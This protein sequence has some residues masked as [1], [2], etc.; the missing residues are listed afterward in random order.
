MSELNSSFSPLPREKLYLNAKSQRNEIDKIVE[1]VS[2]YIT[3]YS[4]STNKNIG[5]VAGSAILAGIDSMFDIGGRV[6]IFSCNSCVSG[7]GACKIR[8]ENNL[9]NTENERN[10]Y[11]PQHDKFVKLSESLT[12]KRIAV[13]LFIFGTKQFDLATFSPIANNTGGSVFFYNIDFNNENDMKYKFEKL[14]YNL[15]RVLTRENFYDVKFM[16][17]YGNSFEVMEILGPFKKRLGSGLSIPSCDPDFSMSFM[18]R[19]NET[20]KNETRQSFQLVALYINNFN[21]RF[22][23]IFNYT[24]LTTSDISKPNLKIRLSVCERG[25]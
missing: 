3:Q 10:L 24:L 16:L 25:Y 4:K 11:N 21:Q 8:D 1:K 15:S 2:A 5:S 13:D 19:I 12:E 17:R 9:Y 6:M 22:L 23:R 14:H 20:M 18:M 7:Y